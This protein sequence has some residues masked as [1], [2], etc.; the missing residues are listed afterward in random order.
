M[1]SRHS[2]C[3]PTLSPE[4]PTQRTRSKQPTIIQEFRRRDPRV[5]SCAMTNKGEMSPRSANSPSLGGRIQ[6]VPREL[7]DNEDRG[8]YYRAA[9]GPSSSR[10]EGRIVSRKILKRIHACELTNFHFGT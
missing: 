2:R 4:I 7:I 8:F 6:E 9:I 5:E 1:H 3:L 10:F